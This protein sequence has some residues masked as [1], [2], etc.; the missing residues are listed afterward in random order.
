MSLEDANGT[1]ASSP[2]ATKE[3]PSRV[4]TASA[5]YPREKVNL[6]FLLV[7]VVA[8]LLLAAAWYGINRWQVRRHAADLIRQADQAEQ[9]QRPNRAAHFLG[10]YVS[11]VPSDIEARARYGLLLER[12]AD[13]SAARYGAL[14]VF[15]QV[16]IRDPERQAIRRRAAALT[17]ELGQF[18]DAVYHL[19]PLVADF[20]NDGEIQDLLGRAYEGRGEHVEAVAHY[21]KAIAAAPERIEAYLRLARLQRDRLARRRDV[22]T[23]LEKLIKANGRSYQAY[24]GRSRFRLEGTPDAAALEAARRDLDEALRLAPQEPEVLFRAAELAVRLPKGLDQARKYLLQALQLRP[25]F[26]PAYESL[27][28][29]ELLANRPDEAVAVFR[30]GLEKFPNQAE[31]LWNLTSLLIQLGQLDESEKML[32]RLDKLSVSRPRRDFLRAALRLQRGDWIAAR[33]QLEDVRPLLTDDR[34]LT[35]QCDLLLA[36]CCDRAGERETELLI[37]RRAIALDAQQIGARLRLIK[38]LQLLG[39]VEEALDECQ[40]LMVGAAPPPAGQLLL[41]QLMSEH[42]LRLP[43]DR[44]KWT[45]ID[46]IL[47][48]AAE[49]PA[50]AAAAAL[51]KAQTR[52]ARHD[53]QGAYQTLEKARIK[54]PRQE[55]LWLASVDLAIADGKLEAARLL[56]KDAEKQLGEGASSRLVRLRV[57][58]GSPDSAKALRD[59]EIGLDKFADEG[60][61]RVLAAL[62]EAHLQAGR[63]AE[64][65]RLWK[66]VAGLRPRDLDARLR[67]FDLALQENDESAMDQTLASIRRLEGEGGT[68]GRFD[69]AR[70]LLWRASRGDKSGLETARIELDAVGKRR[71]NW[72][73]VFLCL[74]EVWDLEGQE[75]L[76]LV[77]Y[78]RAIELGER[79]LELVRRVVRMLYDR[80]RYTEAE[81]VLQ[82][83]PE[84]A[85]LSGDMPQ[86]VAEVSLQSGNYNRALDL[87][88]QAVKADSRDYRDFVWLGQILWAAAQRAEVS[89]SKRRDAEAEAEKALYRAVEMAGNAPEGWVALVQHLVRTRQ[90]DKAEAQIEK[91]RDKLPPTQAPLALAQCYAALNKLDKARQLFDA[92]LKAR[93]DDVAA[94]QIAADFYLRVNDLPEAERCLRRIIATAKRDR[95]AEVKARSLLAVLLA[96]QGGDE[97]AKEALALVGKPEETDR[98]S[99]SVLETVERE[100]ALAVVLSMRPQLA[101]Q[102]K[103]I[104]ILERLSSGPSF[105]SEDRFLLVQLHD[106]V[107]NAIKARERMQPLLKTGNP[108]Y[109]SYYIHSLLRQGMIV[110]A[111]AWMPDLEKVEPSTLRTDVLKARLLKAQGNGEAAAQLLK[112]RSQGQDAP[113]LLRLAAVMEEIGGGSNA[114]DLYRRYAEK[115]KEPEASLPLARCLGK[116]NRIGEALDLCDRVWDKCPARLAAAASLDILQEG[117]AETGQLDRLE[118]RLKSAIEKDRDAELLLFLGSLQEIRGRYDEAENLYRQVLRID[119]RNV[120][121]LNNLAWLLALRDDKSEEALALVNKAIETLGPIT[122]LLDTRAVAYLAEGKADLALV[123]LQEAVARPNLDPKTR[124]GISIHLA[125]AHQ[126]AGN[127][128][129]AKKVWRDSHAAGVRVDTLHGLE[130]A[131][132]NKLMRELGKQEGSGL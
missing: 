2:L 83:L 18:D 122:E 46:R 19:T 65:R 110:E 72:S 16:L 14:S 92:A 66:E 26:I 47:D 118:G 128:I 9:Q 48:R 104:D 116:Q 3:A 97:H 17:V 68:F 53:I 21:Q 112:K 77:H 101:D 62:A 31:L 55:E 87:A 10:L 76:A 58:L 81:L 51:V 1:H 56:L 84:Q 86:L 30:R 125:Q 12:L 37:C 105:S 28:Q 71:P 57:L 63:V 20:P 38:T 64:S 78:Q 102:R 24:L 99:A 5:S 6:R 111:Q 69:H 132:Y 119:S 126:L 117:R 13:S 34:Q 59:L 25:L 43:A 60:R 82:R 95:F 120:I 107:G 113:T 44:Q 41:A 114:V 74:G 121:A 22:E 127:T 49:T 33:N 80:R 35:V 109:L 79:Q 103:A 130:R 98:Q 75:D 96:A 11:M 29:V 27:A 32:E 131:G 123:D 115:V 54:Q 70:Y 23:T 39:R 52:R 15:E 90:T 50:D 40:R 93:P 129:M 42:N 94:L 89:E 85:L 73:R 67:C 36:E 4:R 106:R 61:A 91:A 88:R 8:G 100:R 124:F 7:L 108:R 45:E